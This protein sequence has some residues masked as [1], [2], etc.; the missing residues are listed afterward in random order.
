[1]A[2]GYSTFLFQIDENQGTPKQA[3]IREFFVKAIL[4]RSL[5]PGDALPSTR[6]L[7]EQLKVSRNTVILAYQA[8]MDS[9]YI[10]SL[11]R[12]GF[13]VST[14]AP[15]SQ[16]DA[17]ALHQ[18]KKG[19]DQDDVEWDEKFIRPSASLNI[20]SKP[21][22]WREYEYPFNYG[23]ADSALFSHSEWR[24]CARQALGI[25]DFSITAGDFGYNDDPLLVDYICSHSLPRR[26][27]QV[28][29]SQ[30][31]VTMGAQNALFLL[32]QLLV[33]Q[34][35][36]VVIEDPFYPDLRELLKRHTSHITTLPV[37]QD[38]II[39]NEDVIAQSD[40]VIVTPSHQCPTTAT[41]S[42]DRRRHLLKLAKQHDVLVVEDDY[43][44][45]MNFLEAPSPAL[46][47]MDDS[48]HV[49]YVGS[50]SKSLFPGLRLGYLVASETLIKEAR[51]LRHLMLRHPPG[52]TQRTA[53][54]F[55][56]LGHYDA[57]IR[58]LRR[59]FSDRRQLLQEELAKNDLLSETASHFGGTSFWIK[60]P[61]WL[62]SRKL[63]ERA[64]ESGILIEAGDTFFGASKP[65]LNYFRMA[66]SS[67]PE[68]RIKEGFEKLVGCVK[69]L[70]PS[71]QE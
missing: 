16:I 57:Q 29:P 53:A 60:G 1:M 64:A 35:R 18:D 56:A 11:D 59:H 66:Y 45:E 33:N 40:M 19:V 32:T 10:D 4:N 41:M 34:D 5:I 28:K 2:R 27:I 13:V 46:K 44:F 31:L 61:Q 17:N 30:I 23:Q 67:I 55:M 12:S 20:V 49:I 37:D 48:G 58:R 62:D 25:R 63:A 6:V 9:G 36:K 24:D 15:V 3:Q 51:S 65:P 14:D 52:Q 50:F 43:E 71:M 70:A 26:G 21:L 38:G 22:N 69:S 54:Y 39:I 8:L 47:S 68:D 42:R 7:A